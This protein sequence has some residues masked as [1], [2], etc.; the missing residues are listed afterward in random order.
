MTKKFLK[1]F[2][3]AA[4]MT[5]LCYSGKNMDSKER[6]TVSANTVDSVHAAE[7]AAN[8]D[9]DHTTLHIS[10][11]RN[12]KISIPDPAV[13]G[14]D[15]QI[16]LRAQGTYK[17][18]KSAK[19][20]KLYFTDLSFAGFKKEVIVTSFAVG[21]VT[22]KDSSTAQIH[23]VDAEEEN[24][25]YGN[26][27][28]LFVTAG[29]GSYDHIKRKSYLLLIDY[30]SGNYYKIKTNFWLQDL[31]SF[32]TLKLTDLTGDGLDELIIKKRHNTWIDFEIYRCDA[33]SGEMKM[34][35]SFPETDDRDLFSGHLED[36]YQVVLEYKDINFSQTVSLLDAGFLKKDLDVAAL[37]K[38]YVLKRSE[39]Y[40]KITGEWHFDDT[41]PARCWKNKKLLK[42]NKGAVFLDLPY[43]DDVKV[44]K[45]EEG[46]P[47]LKLHRYV[48][49]GHST[50]SFGDMYV[51]F[52]YDKEL[53]KMVLADAKFEIDKKSR[54]WD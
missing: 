48:Y 8:K 11:G 46:I 2:L 10:V 30:A 7:S 51:Y 47:Q 53:D 25:A 32:N 12:N 26:C 40:D 6:Q 23:Y 45:N 3:F 36:N 33:E 9:T 54:W 15:V 31:S 4:V 37:E 39:W 22:K 52:Q 19:Q 43:S 27:L 44:E 17:S 49:V 13:A 29:T 38:K 16:T 42:K 28:A 35:H 1:L 41:W 34:L 21:S 50:M 14:N 5:C 18:L 24:M 20:R